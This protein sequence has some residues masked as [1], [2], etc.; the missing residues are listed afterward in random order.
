VS[1]FSIKVF[2]TTR[3]ENKLPI[4]RE[5]FMTS[6]LARLGDDYD[7]C[8]ITLGVTTAD[9]DRV[10]TT[11]FHEGYDIPGEVRETIAKAERFALDMELA[12]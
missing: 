11:G 6:L 10:E 9:E 3:F 12:K 4:T 5:R 7:D 2:L 8:S 1:R